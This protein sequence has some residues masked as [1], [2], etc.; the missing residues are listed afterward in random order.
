[1]K[2]KKEYQYSCCPIGTVR[3]STYDGYSIPLFLHLKGV[4]TF[5]MFCGEMIETSIGA[6]LALTPWAA[7]Q[8]ITIS[9]GKF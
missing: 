3:G 7:W 6:V 4:F 9:Q 8:Q 1:M 5:E 2:K